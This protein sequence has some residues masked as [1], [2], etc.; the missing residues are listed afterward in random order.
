[1]KQFKDGDIVQVKDTLLFGEVIECL[2]VNNLEKGI[3]VNA[4]TI[5][6]SD[7][8]THGFL[9]TDLKLAHS[10]DPECECGSKNPIGQGHASWCKLYR[11]ELGL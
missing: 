9:E 8:L 11:R 10:Y 4:Y 1:M 2:Q 3:H 5:R 7:G 6:M